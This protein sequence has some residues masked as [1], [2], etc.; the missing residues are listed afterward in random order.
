[1]SG[2]LGTLVDNVNNP[3]V[4]IHLGDGALQ[5]GRYGEAE[6]WYRQALAACP[7]D[8]DLL[9]NMGTAVWFL[10]RLD[11]AEDYYRQAHRIQPESHSY[12]NN[13][14]NI[15]RARGRIDEAE[16]CYRRS[17]EIAPH[18]IESRINLGV[19]LSDLSRLEESETLLREVVAIRPDIP[20]AHL[21]LGTT[22]TRLGRWDEAIAC[23]EEAVRLRPE[24]PEAR[25]NRAMDWLGRGDYKRGWP[26]Y[27]WRW[28]CHGK[29]FPVGDRPI[30]NGEDLRGRRIVLHAEQ[31]LGDTLQFVRYAERVQRQGADVTLAC[32]R[33]L[34]RLLERCPGID[35]AV[36]VGSPLPATDFQALLMS[37]PANFGTTLA[38][39]PAEVPYLSTD[40]A[41]VERWKLRLGPDSGLRVGI[42]WQGN[43]RYPG[44]S[45]RSFPLEAF[46]QPAGLP[47]I[48]LIRLQHG[49]GSEQ[50]E[51][52]GCRFEVED[53]F[54]REGMSDWDFLD[55]AALI[56]NLDLVVT[57]D[58]AVGHLAGALGVPVWVALPYAS[59]WRWLR[60]REDSPWYPTMR[61]FRQ[62]S[63]GDWDGVF[64]RIS[65]EL[66]GFGTLHRRA[67]MS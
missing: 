23:Y 63:A 4:W 47:G 12:L 48:R 7:E 9:N 49:P 42:A 61:L 18:A 1:M 14:G 38:T 62:R 37:L 10:G 34:L 41:E 11:D 19:A 55:S 15:Q 46:A 32:P 6:S 28:R 58:S 36:A 30:W 51:R 50:I 65:E 35:R 17:L 16:T 39:V 26:E 59:E 29:G 66:R 67:E 20:D 43:P 31:G 33:P 5:C 22:L 8:A 25:R 2:S 64:A 27:E 52:L 54:G 40:P 45:R 53:L 3:A 24:Y 60:D 57:A 56:E 44:D 13:L 21:N